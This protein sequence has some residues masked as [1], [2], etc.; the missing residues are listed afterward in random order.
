MLIRQ[1]LHQRAAAGPRLNPC[2]VGALP[3]AELSQEG[4]LFVADLLRALY[5]IRLDKLTT[6]RLRL[7]PPLERLE[8]RDKPTDIYDV[9]VCIAISRL[10]CIAPLANEVEQQG[11][12]DDR[13]SD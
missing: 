6:L 8:R 2:G 3:L 10:I 7:F 5:N 11:E 4:L 1:T 12:L 13:R 9:F